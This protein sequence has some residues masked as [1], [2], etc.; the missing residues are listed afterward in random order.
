MVQ[1]GTVEL[2]IYDATDTIK[3]TAGNFTTDGFTIGNKITLYNSSNNTA[4]YTISQISTT[5]STNDTI[6]TSES[7]TAESAFN[8]VVLSA[9]TVL[10]NYNYITDRMEADDTSSPQHTVY[11]NLRGRN[12]D[13]TGNHFE[14]N[15]VGLKLENIQ[16]D[17]SR[18]LPAYP[19]PGSGIVTGESRTI[20]ID[21]GMAT[22]NMTLTGII[23]DQRVIRNFEKVESGEEKN[24]SV[25]MTA[26]EIAQLIHTYVDSS[27]LQKYQNLNELIVL[28]PSRVD[29][30]YD[31]HLGLTERTD[32]SSLTPIA[33]LPLIPF[34]WRARNQEN[35]GTIY[36]TIVD[37][38]F[39]EFKP[40]H[41]EKE[42]QGING[43]IRN[44]G[45]NIVAGQPF[46]TFSM[47]FEAADIL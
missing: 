17:T 13:Q 46:V 11:L 27:S 26:Y 33:D 34:S 5:S 8:G 30:Q 31:Y 35:A 45:T 9:E 19:I 44:F 24:P 38:T 16:I 29:G 40:I 3:R 23:T 2:T 37:H 6:T 42:P 39:K 20:G 28:I 10:W 41:R 7:L 22:K 4:T 36:S 43:F 21:L 1:T 18:T 15:R 14:T 12:A 32:D 47:Q 25:V